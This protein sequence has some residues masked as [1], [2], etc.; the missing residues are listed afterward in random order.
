VNMGKGGNPSTHKP[1]D[2]SN[3]RGDVGA[4]GRETPESEDDSFP[5][6]DTLFPELGTLMAE[7]GGSTAAE[8]QPAGNRV[9]RSRLQRSR[10]PLSRMQRSRIQRSSR[11]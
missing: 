6:L 8:R 11:H 1:N 5:E 9:Q 4:E 2:D 7:A 10:M 3:K